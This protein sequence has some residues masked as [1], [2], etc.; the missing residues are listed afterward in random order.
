MNEYIVQEGDSPARIAIEKVGCP[1]CAIDL[2]DANPHKETIV[3]PNGY[4]TF[5]SLRE[6][7]KLNLPD[8]WSDGTLDAMPPEYFAA[9]P[10][11]DGVTPGKKT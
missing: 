2:I 9:L 5:R 6:G 7:E 10:F 1:K 3:Y 8:K 4:K 11:A